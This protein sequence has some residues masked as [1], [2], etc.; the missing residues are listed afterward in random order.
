MEAVAAL[1]TL[2]FLFVEAKLLLVV[3]EG[4]LGETGLTQASDAET[5]GL[6]SQTHS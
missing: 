2:V 4:W 3:G 1:F 5:K 6:K